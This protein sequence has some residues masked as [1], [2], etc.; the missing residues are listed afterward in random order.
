ML[1]LDYLHSYAHLVYK[2]G[3]LIFI[4]IS[5]F[6]LANPPPKT[7]GN[8]EWQEATKEILRSQKA[9]PIAGIS[10]KPVEGESDDDF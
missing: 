9:N 6:F 5:N 3:N 8:K 1:Q 2:K 4:L 7:T 10:S